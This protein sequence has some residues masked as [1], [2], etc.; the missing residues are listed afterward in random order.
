ME[1]NVL[2]EKDGETI[3][4]KQQYRALNEAHTGCSSVLLISPCNF[5]RAS[6]ELPVAASDLYMNGSVTDES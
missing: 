6:W 1:P 2:V 3:Q 4:H 5:C